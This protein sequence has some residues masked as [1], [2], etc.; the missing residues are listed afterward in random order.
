MNAEIIAI[1]SELLTPDRVDTNSLYLTQ[2]LN[3]AGFEV[4]LKT[5]VGDNR[6]DIQ[7]LLRAALQ[8]SRLIV[9]CGGL[10]PT[11]D[12]LTRVA[13]AQALGRRLT[14]NGEVLEGLQRRFAVRG[15][16]MAKINERQAEVIEGAEV[17]ANPAGTAPGM[18]IEANGAAL[19]LLP[20]PPRELKAMFEAA[21]FPRA[22]RMAGGRSMA[23]RT[24]GIQGWTESEVDTR[25]API[26]TSF[27]EVQTTILA[28]KGV[29][30][31]RMQQWVGPG[32]IPSQLDDLAGRIQAALSDTIYSTSGEALE[33]VV[34]S[35][36]RK[37]GRSLALAESCTGGMIG[38]AITRVPGSSEYFRGGIVCYSNEVK[39]SQCRVPPALLERHG[40]VSAEVAEALALG[41]RQALGS[42]I[43]LAVTGIAG[44]GGGT[45]PKPVGLVYVGVADECRCVI[46]RRILPGDRETVREL[47][48]T[49]ALGRLRGFLMSENARA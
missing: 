32:E 45:D 25:I 3:E 28:V 18:W 29:I 9:L 5:V 33:S 41:V 14:L 11:E 26:Y 6:E 38:A 13:T 16:T 39:I 21:V 1:G 35:M 17:L 43:G 44:P 8:R 12:D 2:K 31:L 42:S 49:I 37:S 24:I 15:Y 10:G 40:A 22:A 34:G 30:L 23:T 7:G 27:S 4:R 20:G 19:V 36:L 47:A 46:S 48:A